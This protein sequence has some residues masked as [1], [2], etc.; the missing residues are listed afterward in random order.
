MLRRDGRGQQHQV[1]R[2]VVS[3]EVRVL[4][5]HQRV[6]P[7]S[8]SI[9]ERLLHPR[10]NGNPSLLI[11]IWLSP[12]KAHDRDGNTVRPTPLDRRK[13]RLP[14]GLGTYSHVVSMS[15]RLRRLDDRVLGQPKRHYPRG[16]AL[17]VPEAEFVSQEQA[18][19]ELG[20]PVGRVGWRVACEHMDAAENAARKMGVT[21]SSLDKELAWQ[22]TAGIGRR[23]RR[24]VWNVIQWVSP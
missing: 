23:V 14:Q 12:E 10:L 7:S 6:R 19:A 22:R 4:L 17:T 24:Q 8:Q 9:D 16:M 18:A 15:R 11:R 21:K 20:I 2:N 13:R 3:Q 1:V 5:A